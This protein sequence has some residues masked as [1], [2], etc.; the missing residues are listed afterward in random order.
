MPPRIFASYD[1]LDI[2][3]LPDANTTVKGFDGTGGGG[4]IQFLVYQTT[5]GTSI[6][7]IGSNSSAI[8]YPYTGGPSETGESSAFY[9]A[10]ANTNLTGAGD[11]PPGFYY[12]S[13][14]FWGC[15]SSES[16]ATKINRMNAACATILSADVN[17]Q[18]LIEGAGYHF[19]ETGSY[20]TAALNLN[21]ISGAGSGSGIKL[22]C[23]VIESGAVIVS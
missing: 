13:I 12:S 5:A 15:N 16:Q 3:A 7:E 20:V 8:V 11:I 2:A 14:G 17:Q 4:N 1:Q 9:I 10:F 19:D 21:G 18:T 22:A 6:P 23:I